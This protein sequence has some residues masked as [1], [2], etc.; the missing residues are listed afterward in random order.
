MVYNDG[1]CPDCGEKG[2]KNNEEFRKH[3]EENHLS[4]Y[5]WFPQW[6]EW[7]GLY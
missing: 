2:F 1:V 6:L 4:A 7:R 3:V 5:Y